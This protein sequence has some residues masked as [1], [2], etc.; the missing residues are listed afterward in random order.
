MYHSNSLLVDLQYDC[1]FV[2]DVRNYLMI[3]TDYQSSSNCAFS[4]YIILNLD[5]IPHE[6]SVH[7]RL[8]KGAKNCKP[9]C[10]PF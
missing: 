6:R 9:L 3:C 8:S 5:Q 7:N 2:F 4:T 10:E 1:I